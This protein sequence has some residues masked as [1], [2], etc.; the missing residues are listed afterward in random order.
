MNLPTIGALM[1]QFPIC[2]F[3]IMSK[4]ITYVNSKVEPE[5]HLKPEMN[6]DEILAL[7]SRLP[8]D[9]QQRMYEEDI[10]N[11]VEEQGFYT[12]IKVVSN[13]DTM[14]KMYDNNMSST[15][16]LD[17]NVILLVIFSAM[18]LLYRQNTINNGDQIPANLFT[19][20]VSVLHYLISSVIP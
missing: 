9:I 7:Y 13:N 10:I 19:T 17:I 15:L 20:V 5:Y 12:E 11:R 1:R 18:T 4:V 2:E 6:G 8:F 16:I 3:S 14:K